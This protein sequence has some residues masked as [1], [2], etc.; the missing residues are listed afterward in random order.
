MVVTLGE[1]EWN[2]TKR[3]NDSVIATYFTGLMIRGLTCAVCRGL[4][5]VHQEFRYRPSNYYFMN[6]K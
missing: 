4:S 2:E 6:S 3:K 1:L 5:C